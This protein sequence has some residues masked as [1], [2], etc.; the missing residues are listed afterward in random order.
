MTD[1]LGDVWYSCMFTDSYIHD[2]CLRF[3]SINVRKDPNIKRRGTA[4]SQR[5]PSNSEDL[6]ELGRWNGCRPSGSCIPVN[7]QVVRET[8]SY[9]SWRHS[10]RLWRR[11]P[12]WHGWRWVRSARNMVR[13]DIYK[14]ES[15]TDLSRK[16]GK[17][18]MER[19]SRSAWCGDVYL[20]ST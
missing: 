12:G 15:K 2:E 9:G 5:P 4:K 18:K 10:D 1:R 19:A 20:P 6:D 14:I 17:R 7:M 8:Q 11:E 16:V 13:W 3:E